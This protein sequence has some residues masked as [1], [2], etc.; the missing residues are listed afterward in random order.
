MLSPRGLE[1][2]VEETPWPFQSRGDRK[3]FFMCGPRGPLDIPPRV[4]L[5]ALAIVVGILVF[6]GQRSF[7]GSGTVDEKGKT[8]ETQG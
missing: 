2:I 7:G 6:F 4:S 1:V 3:G 8:K 5:A